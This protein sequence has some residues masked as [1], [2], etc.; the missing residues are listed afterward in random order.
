MADG[1][2]SEP[3]VADGFLDGESEEIVQSRRGHLVDRSEAVTRTGRGV[4]PG[5]KRV[6]RGSPPRESGEPE[7]APH[8]SSR[9]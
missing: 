6:G 1:Q 2:E 5:A 3:A 9:W 4:L 8:D 7:G